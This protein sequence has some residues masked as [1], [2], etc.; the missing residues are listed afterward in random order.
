MTNTLSLSGSGSGTYITLKYR[1]SVVRLRL[2]SLL[3]RDG[4]Q[5]AALISLQ[6][7]VLKHRAGRCAAVLFLDRCNIVF[8]R[9]LSSF[10]KAN[11]K[12]NASQTAATETS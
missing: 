1:P 12:N 7:P 3:A 10:I 8:S 4:L 2:G 5:Q 11:V 6:L 9:F